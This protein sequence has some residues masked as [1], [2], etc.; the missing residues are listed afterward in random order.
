MT[1]ISQSS[2]FVKYICLGR[3]LSNYLSCFA[4]AYISACPL[5]CS[6]PYLIFTYISRSTDFVNVLRLGQFLSNYL[7]CFALAY[8]SACPLEC[9]HPYLTLTYISQ[10]IKHAT[11]S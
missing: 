8:I 5:E 11:L 9:S 3:F 4:L 7:S 1:Y 10:S 2:D 6:H